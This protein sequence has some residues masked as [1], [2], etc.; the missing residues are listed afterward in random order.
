MIEGT[1][2]N[3]RYEKIRE[4]KEK[5]KLDKISARFF[6]LVAQFEYQLKWVHYWE[7]ESKLYNAP[8][9]RKNVLEIYQILENIVISKE[10]HPNYK[11]ILDLC[12]K[13]LLEE[14]LLASSQLTG[15]SK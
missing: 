11:L 4:L 15:K 13:V 6:G 12:K 1:H 9:H 3:E 14:R 7:R 8:A 10:I 2:I 5:G